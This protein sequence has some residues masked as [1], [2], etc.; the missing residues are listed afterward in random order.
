MGIPF[1][2]DTLAAGEDILGR[3]GLIDDIV[4][5]LTK[6]QKSVTLYGPMRSGKETVIRAA[7]D[8][9]AKEVSNCQFCEIDL[10]NVHSK[11]G[12]LKTFRTA[13]EGCIKSV[14]ETS[15]LP[16]D[17]D[18]NTLNDKQLIEFPQ[19]IADKSQN[20]LVIYF[21]E[22]QNIL[23]SE[24]PGFPL[25]QINRIW[26][27]QKNVKYIFTGSCVNMMK[28]MMEEKKLFYYMT[29]E[30]WIPQL[31][32][33]TVCNYITG[34]FLRLGRVIEAEE[35][36]EIYNVTS[37]NMWYVKQLCSIC[38]NKPIGYVN[39]KIVSQST[40]ALLSIH[41][42][43]FRQMIQ[44]L[45][46]NQ[47]NFIKAVTDGVVKFSSAEIMENYH[48]NSSAN[49]FRIKDALKKKEVILFDAEDNARFQDP[50]F[51]YW[52]KNYYFNN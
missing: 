10:F 7:M 8:K 44:D 49:V 30:Y 22:F 41:I 11:E 26:S 13:M 4:R 38:F 12:F 32:P 39:R 27:K 20:M 21:K 16:L 35:A 52:L 19:Y 14:S 2:Y 40:E 42:P 17:I 18:F 43:R 34:S 48:L 25:N 24:E 33:K 51:E 1:A 3:A 45:T 36:L 23:F 15:L 9:V 5:S 50:L 6:S 47:I 29:A 31:D 28:S 46:P 37:G